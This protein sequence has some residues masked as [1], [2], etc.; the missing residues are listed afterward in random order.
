MA[1]NG[2]LVDGGG[3]LG[4][5][6]AHDVGVFARGSLGPVT[7]GEKR[8]SQGVHRIRV[9]WIAVARSESVQTIETASAD[10]TQLAGGRLAGVLVAGDVVLVEGEM[11]SGK[12][13]LVRG[14]C[15]ELG[16]TSPVTSPT[17]TLGRR[18]KGR[19]NVAHL[20]MHRLGSL[21]GEDPALLDDYVDADT[22]TFIEWPEV[23]V[24]RLEEIRARVLL[25]H[26]G[27]DQRHVTISL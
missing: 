17:F 20:D 9:R 11:G 1:H 7:V 4:G 13:T 26:A 10:A 19:V 16:V 23:A 27:G 5:L 24:P 12:T 14:A 21:A 15:R 2:D 3:P 25:E 18:Y 8:D 6:F 22:I